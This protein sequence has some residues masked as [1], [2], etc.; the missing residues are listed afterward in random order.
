MP[1]QLKASKPRYWRFKNWNR[2]S[3]N[4]GGYVAIGDNSI[5]RFRAYYVQYDNTLNMYSDPE[6]TK[7]RFESTHDNSVYGVFGLADL[8]ISQANQLKFSLDYKGD[9]AR[10]Q[11]DIGEPWKEYDQSTLSIGVEDH[12]SF[13]SNLQVVAGLSL[14]YLNK[15]TG[16]NTTRI[17]P[18]IG[19]K[20]SPLRQLDLHL[21][22]S[23]KSRFPSM[24]SMY[25]GSSGNPD[26]LSERGTI[27][28]LG[29]S[30]NDRFLLTGAVFLSRFND[31]IDNVRL[32]EFDFQRRFFNIGEARID[33][34][35]LQIQKSFQKAAFTFNYTFLD[36]WN[37]SDNQ[38]LIALSK[39]NLNFDCQIYPFSRLRLGLWGLLASSSFGLVTFTNDLLDIPSYFNLDVV[40]AYKWQRIELFFKIT[41]IFDN[42]IYT[43][44]GFPWRGRYFELGI[45]ADLLN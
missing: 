14:D 7:Q 40:I 12:L 26:L 44:P 25:S 21:S 8:H 3:F 27:W 36:H 9:D 6:L 4:A 42:F 35:E 23:Q 10:T 32:P 20:Y 22:F 43:E 11:D 13:L 41:N 29:F 17:N 38:P 34:F 31:M 5:A 33:G 39:H 18:L 45:R 2:Y 24:R 30:Y 16:E 28:E 19:V 37:E 15:F 1:P